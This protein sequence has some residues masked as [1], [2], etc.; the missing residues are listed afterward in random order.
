MKGLRL[1]C[2]DNDIVVYFRHLSFYIGDVNHCVATLSVPFYLRVLSR[3][4]LFVRLLR[5]EPRC[6]EFIGERYL[7]FCIL[8]KVWM[9]DIERGKIQCIFEARDGFSDPLNLCK[10]GNCVY[11][12]DYGNN[13]NREEVNIYRVDSSAKIEVVYRFPCGSVRHVHNLI[14]DT[15]NQN[16][17]IFTGDNDKLA[18]I[19]SADKDFFK[20]EAIN[21]GDQRYR[22][23]V[24]FPFNGGVIYATDSVEKDNYLFISTSD[25]GFQPRMLA[26]LNGSCIYGTETAAY[27]VFS[28]TVESPEGRGLFSLLS[29]KLGRGIKSRDVHLIAVKKQ[30]ISDI[31]IIGKFRKDWLPMKLFQYGAVLFPSGQQK[32]KDLWIYPVA[33]RKTDGK[34]FKIRL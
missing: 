7:I 34:L 19:Y 22:A 10:V 9:L 24:G 33:C 11:W 21:I 5:L 28:T 8:H 12:G 16:F 30:N 3:F 4:R 26:E 32:N 27:Y 17:W 31:K 29:N 23:V 14:F 18:G 6:A 2:L 15:K 1:L 20:V 25:T 13:V